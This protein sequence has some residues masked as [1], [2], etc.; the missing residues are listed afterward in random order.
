[1]LAAQARRAGAEATYLGIVRDDPAALRA[2]VARALEADVVL[3]SGGVSLGD[4][5]LVPEVLAA[6]GVEPRFHRWAVKPGGPLWFGVRGAT[7]VFGLPGNPAATFVG[8]ELLVAPALDVRL[9]RP[10]A[11]RATVR[12]TLAGRLPARGARRQFVPVAL[13]ASLEG[14]PGLVAT[15]VR[16][17]GSGDLFALAAAD[18][19]AVVRETGARPPE[20]CGDAHAPA[21]GAPALAGDVVDV[22]PLARGAGPGLALTARPA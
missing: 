22:V 9:G 8:F 1:L 5:D 11:P 20:T 3:V 16:A 18:G 2:A 4:R 12:A 6:C 7:L 15:P 21:S 10:F 19:L 17:M 14:A 13:A